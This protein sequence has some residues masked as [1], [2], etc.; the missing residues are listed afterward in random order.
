MH[1]EVYA[2]LDLRVDDHPNPVA[3]LRRIYEEAKKEYLV[4]QQFLATAANPAG[5]YD[6][7][8]LN[9]ILAMQAEND[10]LR[11]VSDPVQEQ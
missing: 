4:F 7:D 6:R 2:K 8:K 9:E 1:T 11:A 5:V 3:E 10:R